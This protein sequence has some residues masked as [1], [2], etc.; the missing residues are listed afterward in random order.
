[1]TTKPLSKLPGVLSFRRGH[2]V[3]DA[4]MFSLL[5][6]GTEEPIPVI[7]HGVRATQ[8]VNDGKGNDSQK[9]AAGG[10]REVSNIQTTETAKLNA[11][12]TALVIRFSLAM[13][14]MS[15]CIDAVMAKGDRPLATQARGL[16][17]GFVD[18]AKGSKG[19]IEV[20]ARMARNI[21]N[22]R[23]TWRNRAMASAIE[24]VVKTTAGKPVATFD[25]LAIPMN[26]FS[27]YSAAEMDLAQELARQMRGASVDGLEVTATLQMRAGGGVEVFPSQNYVED[28][29]K[30][31]ARPL[32]KLGRPTYRR[33][34]SAT[35]FEDTRVTGVA[36]MRDQKVWNAIR[37]FD[38]WYPEFDDVR[39]PIPVEPLGASLAQQEFFRKGKASSFSLLKRLGEIDPDQPEGMFCI[40]AL[41]RGGVYGESDKDN[42]KPTEEATDAA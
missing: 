4:E 1:M 7:R 16:I 39:V 36:A 41:E 40:A 20:C 19:L 2:I 30:G 9:V 37:T 27:D 5:K 11:E 33:A 28:K 31:F 18:R 35:E 42:A 15:S 10:E 8:N 6:D 12:A 25:A 26:T 23:W 17:Q 3:S 22:A 32:Y 24:V 29:P 34:S 21:G 38:T 14:D 13:L